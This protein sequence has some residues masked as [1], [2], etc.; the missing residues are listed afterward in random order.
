M[1]WGKSWFHKVV[2]LDILILSLHQNRE[3]VSNTNEVRSENM[4]T[5]R[6]VFL[7]RFSNVRAGLVRSRRNIMSIFHNQQSD[8]IELSGRGTIW[9]KLSYKISFLAFW[10][11]FQLLNIPF[12]IRNQAAVVDMANVPVVLMM[13]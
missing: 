1:S 13:L 2:K 9:N 3:G 8:E 7:R 11:M 4:N 10:K 6:N 12:F 5:T